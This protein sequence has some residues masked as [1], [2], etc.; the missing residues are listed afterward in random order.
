MWE[1]FRLLLDTFLTVF[2]KIISN[3]QNIIYVYFPK[4]QV[5]VSDIQKTQSLV[6]VK[7]LH[8]PTPIK[9]KKKVGLSINKIK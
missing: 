1:M 9:K 3:I 2:F 5:E 8:S 4:P 6:A 7:T